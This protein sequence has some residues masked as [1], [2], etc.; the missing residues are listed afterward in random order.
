LDP[1]APV[2]SWRYHVVSLV[3]VVLAFGLGILAGTSV[4]D[5]GFTQILQRNYDDA[6][7]QRDAALA[8]AA[9]SGRF[10]EALQPTLRDD[11]LL[12]E[13]AIVITMGGVDGPARRTVQEL[14]AAGVEVLAR[15]ELTPTLAQPEEETATVLEAILGLPGA[16]PEELST[17]VAEALAVRLGGV[18]DDEED[19]LGLLLEGGLVA[20]DRDLDPARLLG[21]GVPG[22]LVVI[23]A[24]GADPPGFPSP[25]ALLVPLTERLVEVDVPT[26]V[27]G[28]SEDAYG[29]VG[30]VRDAVGIPD[31]SL[32]SVDDIDLEGIGG[33]TMVMGIER[34]LAD[35]DPD[36]RP[37]GDYGIDG[38]AMIV[39]GAAEPPQ[40]C[41][42]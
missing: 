15:L 3:A 29:F 5:E 20:S 34:F 14:E 31:C 6:I 39:P 35:D 16:D 41:R 38:D 21:I 24:G 11:E 26:T 12:G 4:I 2:I 22:Q 9:F 17:A 32:V 7:Q 19:V 10:A 25:E 8:Q 1:V 28:P 42:A 30:A 33:I 13:E 40:S 36:L 23:A 18:L 27:V 37:G